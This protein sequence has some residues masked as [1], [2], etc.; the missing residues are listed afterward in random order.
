MSA[1]AEDF[2]FLEHIFQKNFTTSPKQK[3]MNI[4]IEFFR[5]KLV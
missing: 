5:F 3:K 4:T 2:N 1:S